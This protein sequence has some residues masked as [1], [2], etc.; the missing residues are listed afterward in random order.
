MAGVFV[1]RLVVVLIVLVAKI[2]EKKIFTL[3]FFFLSVA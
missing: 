2:L 1:G 3:L